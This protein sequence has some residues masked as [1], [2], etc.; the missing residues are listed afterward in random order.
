[1]TAQRWT[2]V[3]STGLYSRY[4]TSCHAHYIDS[5]SAICLKLYHQICT[6]QSC[7]RRLSKQHQTAI[8]TI[9][10]CCLH[11]ASSCADN[12]NITGTIYMHNMQ[13]L[14]LAIDLTDAKSSNMGQNAFSRINSKNCKTPEWMTS[15][16]RYFPVVLNLL[17]GRWG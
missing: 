2:Q 14:W 13:E 15:H 7:S 1:M 6:S 9:I 11:L 3:L 10:R 16:L 8:N 5:L 4:F 17:R 12:R